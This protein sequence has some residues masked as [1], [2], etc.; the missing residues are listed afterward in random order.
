MPTPIA[1]FAFNRPDHLRRTLTALAANDLAAASDITI[2]CDGPRNGQEKNLTDAA[3]DVAVAASGFASVNIVAREQNMGCANAVI[4]GLEYMFTRHERLVV[5]EDDILCSPHTLRFLNTG[6]EKYAGEPVVF[7]IAAW[8]PPPRL[9]PV[10]EDYPYDVYF[11]PRFNCWGWASWRDRWAKVDWSVFDYAVF[12]ENPCLQRAFNQGGNDMAAM[13]REQMA[14]RLNTWDIQMDYARFRHGC[15]G[16]NP[17]YSYTTNIGMGSGTHTTGYNT[18]LDNDLGRVVAAP[19]LPEHVFVDADIAAAY[20]KVYDKPSLPVR[21]VN[22][23][24]R[25]AFGKNF[26]DV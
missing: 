12:A 3:R 4:S 13:L 17:V 21:V 16:L 9:M 1:V 15:L 5:V 26:F 25:T 23:A 24:W 18:R 14:G 8:S 6:L 7:N 11:V 20:R 2:F 22:K 10:P 19:R